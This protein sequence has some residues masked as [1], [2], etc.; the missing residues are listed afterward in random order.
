MYN[1]IH[2]F[3]LDKNF[4]IKKYNL[5]LFKT[6]FQHHYYLLFIAFLLL[7][8]SHKRGIRQGIT[9]VYYF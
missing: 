7:I 5:F 2:S 1:S 9:N 6:V 3:S 4:N 8:V